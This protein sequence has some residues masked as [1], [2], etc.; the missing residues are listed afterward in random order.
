MEIK[1]RKA[2][3]DYEIIETFLSGIVLLGSEVKSIRNGKVSFTDS[4][5]MFEN[6][7]L[8]LKNLHISEYQNTAF[9]THDPKRDKKL[10]LTKKE[11]RKLREKVAEKGLTIIPL[12]MFLNKKNTFKV[13][14][15]LAKGKKNY[16]K[17]NKIL[18]KDIERENNRE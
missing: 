14:I 18:T 3:F 5:C 9:G 7:E 10:L 1:N 11:L 2:R 4:Y 16:D 13:E 12:K 15:A 17:R 8:F 6:N